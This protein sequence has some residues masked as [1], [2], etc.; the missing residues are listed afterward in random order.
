MAI[1]EVAG[2]S[3]EGLKRGAEGVPN[4]GLYTTVPGAPLRLM[5]M[6]LMINTVLNNRM[7]SWKMTSVTLRIK[8]KC[9]H[10]TRSKEIV[11][12][13]QYFSQPTLLLSG[14]FRACVCS[15]SFVWTDG[16]SIQSHLA[17]LLPK[18][19]F[20]FIAFPSLDI[21]HNY[22]LSLPMKYVFYV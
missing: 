9:F 18:C 5:I 17:L 19:L 4:L 21:T 10:V 2:S 8:N 11:L 3:R 6:A 16:G 22:C 13:K 14:E 7:W 1:G 15:C 20:R 12:L